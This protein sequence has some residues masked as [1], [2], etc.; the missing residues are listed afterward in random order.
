MTDL[1]SDFDSLHLITQTI[2]TY[3]KK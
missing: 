3:A 2:D 1:Y